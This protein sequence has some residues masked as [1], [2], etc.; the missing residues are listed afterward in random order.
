MDASDVQRAQ[1]FGETVREGRVDLPT[2]G[3]TT[4]DVELEWSVTRL[5]PQMQQRQRFL[6]GRY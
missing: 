5:L 3:A 4:N 1:A 6:R 2:A